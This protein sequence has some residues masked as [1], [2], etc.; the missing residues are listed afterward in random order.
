MQPLA[1]G[2]KQKQT[3]GI[4]IKPASCLN[5]ALHKGRGEQIESGE[6]MA[7]TVAAFIARRFMQHETQLFDPRQ[8]QIPKAQGRTLRVGF[9]VGLQR[10]FWCFRPGYMHKTFP[11]PFA[12]FTPGAEALGE[13]TLFG[14]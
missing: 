8:G 10:S 1:I 14:V 4:G 9:F 13:D 11:Q 3:G 12:A 6:V 7:G 2:A 5:A